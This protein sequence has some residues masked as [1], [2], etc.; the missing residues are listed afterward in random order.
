MWPLCVAHYADDEVSL[1]RWCCQLENYRTEAL[2]KK[3]VSVLH[4]VNLCVKAMLIVM[5]TLASFKHGA[6]LSVPHLAIFEVGV[7]HQEEGGRPP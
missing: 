3:I 7:N 5:S 1:C 2:L 6:Q 4:C